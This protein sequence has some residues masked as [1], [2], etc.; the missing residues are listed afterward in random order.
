MASSI[1]FVSFNT[2]GLLPTRKHPT[3]P[4]RLSSFLN[5]PQVIALQET[6]ATPVDSI[7][8]IFR[9]HT[10]TVADDPKANTAIGASPSLS[11]RADFSS[12]YVSALTIQ[13]ALPIGPVTLVS[14]Y[15]CPSN[16][17]SWNSGL[18]ELRRCLS[19]FPPYSQLVVAGDFN[20]NFDKP[21]PKLS[22]L[23]VTLN[24]AGLTKT[25]NDS[26]T[27]YDSSGRTSPSQIDAIF[28]RL[29]GRITIS[30]SLR[31]SRLSDHCAIYLHL[32]TS[33]FTN[34]EKRRKRLLTALSS[35]FLPPVLKKHISRLPS[36]YPDFIKYVHS[37]ALSVARVKRS[38]SLAPDPVNSLLHAHLTSDRDLWN[39][40]SQRLQ[41]PS[42]LLK[43]TDNTNSK[44]LHLQTMAKQQK[45][46]IYLDRTSTRKRNL[47]Y[48]NSLLPPKSSISITILHPTPNS[49]PI[50]DQKVIGQ[51]ISHAWI[52]IFNGKDPPICITD[53]IEP[54]SFSD[55]SQI[56][57]DTSDPPTLA[58]LKRAFNSLPNSAP[59]IDGIPFSL[60]SAVPE[61]FHSAVLRLVKDLSRGHVPPQVL[62]VSLVMI[63]K[64]DM[65]PTPLDL[66]PISIPN[67]MIRVIQRWIAHTLN[68]YAPD[69]LHPNQHAF[70]PGRDIRNNVKA[71]SHFLAD[72]KQGWLLFVDFKK[73]YDSVS[74]KKLLDI[75]KCCRAQPSVINIIRSLLTPYTARLV[76]DPSGSFPIPVTQGVPQGSPCSPFLFNTILDPI[77]R[78]LIAY[79][80]K[81]L[82]QLFADDTTLMSPD[83][84]LLPPAV[85][86]MEKL[87]GLVGLQINH[88]KSAIL[89]LD[90]DRPPPVP[91][92]WGTCPLVTRFKH[93]G[94]W[95]GHDVSLEDIYAD[96]IAKLELRSSTHSPKSA[97]FHDRVLIWNIY[98]IPLLS[99]IMRF[100]TVPPSVIARTI[101]SAKK[102]LDPHR[103]LP[104]ST[105]LG[106]SSGH[107]FLSNP[108]PFHPIPFAKRQSTK[109]GTIF[110]STYPRYTPPSMA[111]FSKKL[112]KFITPPYI[113]T[114]FDII[115]HTK[116]RLPH[117][118]Q[119]LLLNGLFVY[120][121]IHHF[122]QDFPSH[123]R[124]CGSLSSDSWPHMLTQCST[125]SRTITAILT[126]NPSYFSSFT[127]S[128]NHA[129][130]FSSP[131]RPE[132]ILNHLTLIHTIWIAR[133]LASITNSVP[134]L[135]TS[136]FW[137]L[138]GKA[139]RQGLLKALQKADQMIGPTTPS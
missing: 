62:D 135:L 4:L 68:T 44:I 50:F 30:S 83:N 69:I 133:Y 63:R 6:H 77:I 38:E 130:M 112:A 134:H 43:P 92:R 41:L 47:S 12:P 61:A 109:D 120:A 97:P 117:T 15:L 67:T 27:W 113:L 139:V 122:W 17:S 81:L 136:L 40:I 82:L 32:C 121:R 79:S 29:G 55:W 52:P 102:V 33:P 26:P 87:F 99:Y 101:R 127:S 2:R 124:L 59:G 73:A 18:E 138:R 20:V 9:R 118:Y 36:Y 80:P 98:I 31:R 35:P 106:D 107:P 89:H 34:T 25:D 7:S 137:D 93:L 95:I 57:L 48:L 110:P 70:V 56:S 90:P 108:V 74:R 116:G 114:N 94:I 1:T 84:S 66:R 126:D 16:P 104:V 23:M 5:L 78:K 19:N 10:W 129:L 88:S 58:E 100:H 54:S 8:S 46:E 105:L 76:I 37:L 53:Y 13:M 72:N 103:L 65:A 64:K 111:N 21:S 131:L 3:K 60:V 86:W 132:T 125:V 24:Q 91:E 115:R 128:L 28:Y 71:V 45:F 85:S 119:L 96:A 11:P 22:K 49:P 123:C 75:L 14:V 51:M 42:L 39:R